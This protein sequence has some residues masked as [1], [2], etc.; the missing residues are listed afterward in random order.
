MVALS[1]GGEVAWIGYTFLNIT[2]NKEEETKT[3]VFRDW[4]DNRRDV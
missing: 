2:M 1:S 3:L 4:R